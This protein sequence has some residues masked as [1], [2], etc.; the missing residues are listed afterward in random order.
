M[1]KKIVFLWDSSVE[2]WHGDIETTKGFL[3][4]LHDKGITCELVDTKDMTDEVL[5][6]WRDQALAASMRHK[7]EI[8]KQFGSRKRGGEPYLGKQVPALLVYKEDE[9]VPTAVYPHSEKRAEKR[10]E[11]SIE[12]FL[13]GLA[14]SFVE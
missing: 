2:P 5:Q 14:N 6:H 10:T 8:H 9:K 13:K 1:I 3:T 4:E 11:H 7:L 12:D